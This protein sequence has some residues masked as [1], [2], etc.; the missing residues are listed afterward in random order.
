MDNAQFMLFL[1]LLGWHCSTMGQRQTPRWGESEAASG[2]SR[3]APLFSSWY[4][5]CAVKKW[6][7]QN[8][9]AG[10]GLV[11]D[12]LLFTHSLIINPFHQLPQFP[13]EKFHFLSSSLLISW[14]PLFS[15]F[16][17]PSVSLLCLKKGFYIKN[18]LYS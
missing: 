4:Q 15:C 17:L 16:S 10:R 18:T 7:S 14:L 8:T 5:C 13:T 1:L 6:L 11:F 12:E 2:Q 9:S 3:N